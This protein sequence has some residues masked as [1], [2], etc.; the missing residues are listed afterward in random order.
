MARSQPIYLGPHVTCRTTTSSAAIP[1]VTAIL[2]EVCNFILTCSPLAPDIA[3]ILSGGRARRACQ[4]VVQR[5]SS[6]TAYVGL[7]VSLAMGGGGGGGV[8]GVGWWGGVGDP[9]TPSTS[10]FLLSR[11]CGA[12][13]RNLTHNSVRDRSA[14]TARNRR[15]NWAACAPTLRRQWKSRRDFNFPPD[16]WI[17]P[18]TIF[19]T[20]EEKPRHVLVTFNLL[21][22]AFQN[23]ADL[24][25]L[26]GAKRPGPPVA[27]YHFSEHLPG[28]QTALQQKN[29]L[30]SI[31]PTSSQNHHHP[32]AP[33]HKPCQIPDQQA[34]SS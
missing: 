2:Q 27:R 1:I 15:P 23:V 26:P 3:R 21:A 14:V 34:T 8:V 25:V 11:S 32:S 31:G 17:Q 10:L 16:R 22:F 5:C 18:R 13:E 29:R 19:A 9:R 4:T 7:P 6:S 28:H 20:A 12:S 30:P 24:C 33:P